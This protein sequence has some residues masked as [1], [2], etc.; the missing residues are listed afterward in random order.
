VKKS[1]LDSLQ[2]EDEDIYQFGC[3]FEFYVDTKKYNYDD[4]VEQIKNAIAD[5]SNADILVDLISL[6]VDDDKNHCVQIK[7]D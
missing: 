4:A 1:D 3:E 6:P 2:V 7:P 5:F